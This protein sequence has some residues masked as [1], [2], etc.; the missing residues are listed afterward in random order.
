ME[1]RSQEKLAQCVSRVGELKG[2]EQV[3]TQKRSQLEQE[4][5]KLQKQLANEKVCE[6]RLCECAGVGVQVL[7]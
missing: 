2:K 4:I 6:E 3:M 5:D 7:V 1:S